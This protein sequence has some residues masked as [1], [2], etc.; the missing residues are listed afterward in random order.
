M[1]SGYISERKGWIGAIRYIHAISQPSTSAKR[2][3]ERNLVM[4]TDA[5]DEG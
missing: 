4:V 1:V 2:G 3:L 5:A